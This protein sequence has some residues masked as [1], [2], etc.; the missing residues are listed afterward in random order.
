MELKIQLQHPQGKKAVSISKEK[1]ELLQKLILDFFS[2]QK[3][4]SFT[5]IANAIT[6]NFKENNLKFQGSLKWYLEWVKLDLEARGILN[7][8]PGTMPQKYILNKG[9]NNK[10]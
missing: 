7:R 6:L 3:E 2:V 1:Y 8:L 4:G 9:I 10:T 5:E